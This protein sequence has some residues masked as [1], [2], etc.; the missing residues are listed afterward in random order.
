MVFVDQ[1]SATKGLLP[2]TAEET[3]TQVKAKAAAEFP[4]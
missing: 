4:S 1:N 3:L 2:E